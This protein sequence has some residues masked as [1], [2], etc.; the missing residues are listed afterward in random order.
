M[1]L[2]SN[3]QSLKYAQFL[4]K[5]QRYDTDENWDLIIEYVTDEGIPIYRVVDGEPMDYYTEPQGMNV[6]IAESGGEA[7]AMAFG[8]SVG[9]YEA[10]LLYGRGEYPLKE[11]SLVWLDSPVEYEYNGA[12]IN[13]ELD[14]G[15]QVKIKAPDKTSADYTVLKIARSL[16]FEKAVLKAVVK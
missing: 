2:D 10:V 16:N 9:D 12:E 1:S 15:E 8:L 3:K 6:N 5:G 11:G 14:S 4:T 7:E 13:V